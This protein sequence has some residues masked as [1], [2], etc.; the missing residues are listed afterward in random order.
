VVFN[1][2]CSDASGD[3]NLLVDYIDITV[4][5]TTT[6][7]QAEGPAILDYG[8]GDAK[9]DGV[10][11]AVGGQGLYSNSALRFVFAPDNSSAAYGY[12]A[13]GNVSYKLTSSQA[14]LFIFDHENHLTEIKRNG[15]EL[16][17]RPFGFAQGKC[18]RPTGQ[19]DGRGRQHLLLL[20]PL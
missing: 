17:L 9:F 7:I 5:T 12:D 15:V 20:P 6:R 16:C 13:N 3:R 2:D 1:N 8:A 18:G 11:L 10:N 19:E 14:D 4:G